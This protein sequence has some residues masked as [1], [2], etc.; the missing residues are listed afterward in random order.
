MTKFLDEFLRRA[1]NVAAVPSNLRQVKTHLEQVGPSIRLTEATAS[2]LLGDLDAVKHALYAN[3][4]QNTAAI[5]TLAQQFETL[6]GTVA[7]LARAV[8]ELQRTA[9][10][11]GNVALPGNRLL[12][13][14]S[15][16]RYFPSGDPI[17][18]VNADDKLIV[19]KLAMNGYYELESSHFVARNIKPN[20]HVVDVGA[21]F[22]YYAVMMGLLAG[23]K[24]KVLA[25]E[26]HPGMAALLQENL[27]INWI[28][29]GK[30]VRA[31]CSDKAGEM[32][33]FTSQARAANTGLLV[34]EIDDGFGPD[35]AFSP[36]DVAT[37]AIDD[38]LGFLDGRVDFMKIDVEGAE[39]L[40][41]R[42][43][44]QTIAAN[45]GIKI[46][47]EWSP[48]Q[49]KAGG[50]ELA[51]VAAELKGLGLACYS[52]HG[53]G[54][55]GDVTRMDFETLPEAGYQNIVLMRPI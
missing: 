14:I 5:A 7:N 17:L 19:P 29:G 8:S 48:D 49:L 20:D 12:T 6:Q 51:S 38:S 45:P 43:A 2:R 39:L 30:V 55:L 16:P 13:R 23:W 41:L 53:S 11:R 24:G 22:G 10:S 32:R 31:A 34:P 33:L 42:G 54:Q 9:P 44:R 15:L 27:L 3:A 52:L 35:F 47:M 37:V 26:P 21:N 36:I 4:Q 46:L 50:F 1:R 25:F 40:V 28:A 18:F